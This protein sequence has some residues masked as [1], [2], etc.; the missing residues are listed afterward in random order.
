[1]LNLSV[2]KVLKLANIWQSYKQEHGCLVHFLRLLYSGVAAR[3]TTCMS[4]I[5]FY[6]LVHKTHA[7]VQRE[8]QWPHRQ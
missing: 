3:Y 4:Q 8:L 6:V 1:M 2:K 7:V 5:C